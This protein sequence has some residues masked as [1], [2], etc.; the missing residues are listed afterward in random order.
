MGWNN[1]TQ[2]QIQYIFKQITP[3]IHL[4]YLNITKQFIHNVTPHA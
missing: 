1:I 4:Q 2:N 3:K